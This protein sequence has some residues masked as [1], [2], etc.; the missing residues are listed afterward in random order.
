MELDAYPFSPQFG[1]VQDRYGLSWQLNLAGRS[2]K[3]TPF[4][5]FVGDQH[6]RAEA[7]MNDYV[8]LFENSSITAIQRRGPDGD[9]VEG[10]V[11]HAVFTLAGQ[12]FMASD[13]GLEHGFTFT[14]ALSFFVN[15]ETQDEV[16]RLWEGLSAGGEKG[17]CGWLTDRYGVS[18]QVV[19]TILGELMQDEDREKATRV[20]QAMLQMTK[21][22]IGA[23]QAAYDGK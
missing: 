15:C 6:A 3:I 4:L 9:G 12:A 16:D 17:V 21:L 1:W 8:D 13:G 2:Q 10:T 19:P 7:A 22:D 20:T 23:L 11:Q 14:P 5:T 18:W